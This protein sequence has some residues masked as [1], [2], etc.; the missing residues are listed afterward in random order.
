[1]VMGKKEE[2]EKGRERSRLKNDRKRFRGKTSLQ[3]LRAG[4]NAPAKRGKTEGHK[5]KGAAG[6]GKREK[7]N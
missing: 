7:A 3:I 1:M 2:G 6:R 5:T 4:E